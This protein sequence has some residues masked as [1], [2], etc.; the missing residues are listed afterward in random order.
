MCLS[1]VVN[2]LIAD[3]VS[4]EYTCSMGSAL[5]SYSYFVLPLSFHVCASSE[6]L[7]VIGISVL[8]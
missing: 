1:C 4:L 3:N 7:Y 5:Q 2:L 8:Q 6:R